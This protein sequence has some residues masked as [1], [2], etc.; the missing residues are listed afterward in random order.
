[1]EDAD[2][3]AVVPPPNANGLLAG[4]AGVANPPNAAAGAGAVVDAGVELPPKLKLGFTMPVAAVAVGE[5]NKFVDSFFC[6]TDAK[7]KP[8]A[9]GGCNPTP[10]VAGAVGCCCC[11]C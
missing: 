5:L 8:P 9:R 3:A 1:M 11:C 7:E 10:A 4:G 2:G 6:A